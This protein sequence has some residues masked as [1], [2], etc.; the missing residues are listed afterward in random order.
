MAATYNWPNIRALLIA[1]FTED[2]LRQFCFDTPEFKPLYPQLARSSS[3]AD[4]ADQLIEYADQ[5]LKTELLLVWAAEK[6]LARFEEHQ[7]YQSNVNPALLPSSTGGGEIQQFVAELAQVRVTER[8]DGG[9]EAVALPSPES[10]PSPFDWLRPTQ[11][12]ILL[13]VIGVGLIMGAIWRGLDLPSPL[14][15]LPGVKPAQSQIVSPVDCAELS[16]LT[17]DY[18]NKVSDLLAE[19]EI[20]ATVQL[21]NNSG[22]D[23]VMVREDNTG[24]LIQIKCQDMGIAYY[25]TL[26]E[27]EITVEG[28]LA[29]L[30]TL[31]LT[32]FQNN[33]DT[34][35]KLTAAVIAYYSNHVEQAAAWLFETSSGWGES[36]PLDQAGWEFLLGNA[37]LQHPEPSAAERAPEPY[38]K[39]LSQ[40][41]A[42]G[43]DQSDLTAKA[44]YNLGQAYLNIKKYETA[45]TEFTLALEADPGYVWARVSRSRV[46][47]S[48]NRLDE[49]HQDCDEVILAQSKP[50]PGY[51]CRARVYIAEES[52]S[53]ALEA[54]DQAIAQD[55]NY[56]PAYFYAGLSYCGQHDTEAAIRSFEQ[57]V[58]S[59]REARFLNLAENWLKL[60]KSG[61][62]E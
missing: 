53:K 39:A 18:K 45:A 54:I 24:V 62:C 8:M 55:L 3:A 49:G 33:V 9:S 46:Y 15:F 51:A 52:W 29:E 28:G 22:N 37:W 56:A 13:S 19:A 11:I 10:I 34:P 7:P 58:A 42:A 6:N 31:S 25:L 43:G 57:A 47:A 4:I 41:T 17:T 20:T 40:V 30:E 26:P 60:S 2:E 12:H 5:K 21:E 59:A 35:A 14:N 44:H 23:T 1:G 50:A 61:N 16:A 27:R 48:I 38:Q 32:W 36:S